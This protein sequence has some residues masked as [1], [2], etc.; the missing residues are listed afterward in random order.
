MA[1]CCVVLGL[2]I[3]FF[4]SPVESNLD[5]CKN[6]ETL[7]QNQ[8]RANVALFYN[9]HLVVRNENSHYS[10]RVRSTSQ[11][12]KAPNMQYCVLFTTL[13][14][15]FDF[16]YC[17]SAL[18]F[19]A[20]I[21]LFLKSCIIRL[22]VLHCILFRVITTSKRK[23]RKS[24]N[25]VTFINL[26][27]ENKIR[28]LKSTSQFLMQGVVFLSI[29]YYLPIETMLAPLLVWHPR[30]KIPKADRGSATLN[31]SYPLPVDYHPS[32]ELIN[33]IC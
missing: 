13:F 28:S 31:K 20:L 21:L 22:N 11:F 18:L 29:E 7:P 5:L 9:L 6:S 30:F 3:L 33:R 1:R 10:E 24:V 19:E 4:F 23:K 26:Q 17:F 2:V 12:S 25:D 32:F 16:H 14:F 15:L 8:A 27:S